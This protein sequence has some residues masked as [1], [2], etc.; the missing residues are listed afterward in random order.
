MAHSQASLENQVDQL[1]PL[2]EPDVARMR[3]RFDLL[4]ATQPESLQRYGRHL[5][6]RIAVPTWG[7]I[8]FD[9]NPAGAIGGSE[10]LRP[11]LYPHA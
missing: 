9:G 2:H 7:S 1:A 3:A 5:F 11:G 6:E 8:W 10:C 4:L